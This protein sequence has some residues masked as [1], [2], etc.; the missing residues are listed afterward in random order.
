MKNQSSNGHSIVHPKQ[1][2][3]MHYENSPTLYLT[4]MCT[5]KCGHQPS[6]SEARIQKL[7]Q[8]LTKK[9][10]NPFNKSLCS[11]ELYNLSSGCPVSKDICN[12]ILGIFPN[13]KAEHIKFITKRLESEGTNSM[14][15]SSA[16]RYHCFQT[17]AGML[18]LIKR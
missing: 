6:S 17:V 2:I 4:G 1:K 9:Y 11:D 13:G 12:K 16:P 3:L 8:V 5:R 18:N 14:N 7:V 15:Q 10:I